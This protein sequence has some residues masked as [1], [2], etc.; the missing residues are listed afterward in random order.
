ML[1]FGL[2]LIAI[3]YFVVWPDRK[4]GLNAAKNSETEELLKKRFVGGEIDE[5]TYKRMLR[6]LRSNG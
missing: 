5:D 2:I 6:T 1:L 4:I 3:I